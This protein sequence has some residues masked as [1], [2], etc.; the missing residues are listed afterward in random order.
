MAGQIL[1]LL[2]EGALPV[3]Q[4]VQQH[5]VRVQAQRD[6]DPDVD[7]QGGVQLT[8][9]TEPRAEDAGLAGTTFEHQHRSERRHLLKAGVGLAGSALCALS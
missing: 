6:A 7:Q 8:P 9:P 2:Q 3:W 5:R 4:Q 1:Q